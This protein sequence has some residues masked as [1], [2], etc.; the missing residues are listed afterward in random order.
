MTSFTAGQEVIGW[1]M[2]WC[3][4]KYL[5]RDPA[6]ENSREKPLGPECKYIRALNFESDTGQVVVGD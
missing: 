1:W 3:V 6:G 2:K 4:E 5:F